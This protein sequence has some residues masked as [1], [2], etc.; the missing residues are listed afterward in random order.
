MI[1]KISYPLISIH[2]PSLKTAVLFR[3]ML[4]KEQKILLVAKETK[5]PVEILMATKQVIVNCC[6]QEE[7]LPH[8]AIFDIEMIFIKLY[9]GSVTNMIA[10]GFVDTEDQKER[11]FQVDLSK[12]EL[13]QPIEDIEPIVYNDTTI[14]LAY[15]PASLYSDRDFL[16]A[17][18]AQLTDKLIEKSIKAVCVGDQKYSVADLAPDELNQWIDD[19][20]IPIENGIRD[21]FGSLPTIKYTIEYQNDN[22]KDRKIVL[23][24]LNDFF[25]W[26]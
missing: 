26:Y 3:P 12:V 19:L 24:T 9:A 11:I 8:L 23:S 10:M 13:S 2:V 21:F 14:E 17:D 1:P 5:D 20:P 25:T 18:S 6:T 4:V 15:P 22:G 7:F 16:N